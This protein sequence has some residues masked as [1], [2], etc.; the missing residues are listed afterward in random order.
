MAKYYS[1]N[2]CYYGNLPALAGRPGNYGYHYYTTIPTRMQAPTSG[3]VAN[4]VG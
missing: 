4:S 1:C 2:D 3:V